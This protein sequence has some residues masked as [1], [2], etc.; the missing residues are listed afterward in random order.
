MAS[1]SRPRLGGNVQSCFSTPFWLLFSVVTLFNSTPARA[2]DWQTEVNVSICNWE[3]L[4]A[5]I[6]RDTIY[7]DGGTIWW[8]M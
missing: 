1:A 3:Q 6:I 5:N 8:Q 7:L 2:I 4:R